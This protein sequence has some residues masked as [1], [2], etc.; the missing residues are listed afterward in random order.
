MARIWGWEGGL[1]GEMWRVDGVGMGDL[2]R[3]GR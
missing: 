3:R 1:V 2:R